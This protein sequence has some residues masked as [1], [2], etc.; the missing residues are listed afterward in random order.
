MLA[1]VAFTSACW[2]RRA[3]TPDLDGTFPYLPVPSRTLPYPP[4]PSRTHINKGPAFPDAAALPDSGNEP[5]A[6]RML[7]VRPAVQVWYTTQAGRSSASPRSPPPHRLPSCCSGWC[8]ACCTGGW[9]PYRT[10]TWTCGRY[11]QTGWWSWACRWTS[12]EAGRAMEGGR[13]SWGEARRQGRARACSN[14]ANG[15]TVN[16]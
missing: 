9:R 7:S 12:A 10:W 14:L 6:P 5:L 11:P 4:V 15:S 13:R 16:V 2:L 3:M 8:T 1:V